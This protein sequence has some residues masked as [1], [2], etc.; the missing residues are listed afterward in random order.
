MRRKPDA[1][2]LTAGGIWPVWPGRL[3]WSASTATILASAISCAA[4]PCRS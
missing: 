4:R 2:R 3:G 1:E